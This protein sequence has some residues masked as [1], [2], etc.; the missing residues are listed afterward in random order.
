MNTKQR[1]WLGWGI[2]AVVL[3]ALAI[4][5]GVTYPV[6]S[7]PGEIEELGTTLFDNLRVTGTSDLR[8]TISDGL[9][10]LTIGDDVLISGAAD[11]IQLRVTGYTTQTTDLLVLEQAGGTDVFSVGG[12][13]D[14]YL[15]RTADIQGDVFDGAGDFTIADNAVI[16]GTS[17]LQGNVADSLGTFTIADDASVTGALGVTGASTLGGAVTVN[18]NATITGT[19]QYGTPG[20]YPLGYASDGYQVFYGTTSLT[21]T[22]VYT[23]SDLSDAVVL[24]T[25]AQDVS[26]V[27]GEGAFCTARINSMVMPGSPHEV[28]VSVWQDDF[29]VATVVADVFWWVV[30]YDD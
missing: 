13:G 24:C 1:E 11:A 28:I 15:V 23:D 4:F 2:L 25:L 26:T 14:M 27:A 12:S 18:D 8:G 3:T 22:V 16:T 19:L 10:T 21:Q 6:P 20:L 9:G 5:L 30:D 29:T 17:D 7:A